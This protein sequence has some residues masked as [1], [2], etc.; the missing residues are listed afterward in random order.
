[1]EIPKRYTWDKWKR[2]LGKKKIVHSPKELFEVNNP[3]MNYLETENQE[4]M[5]LIEL[6]ITDEDNETN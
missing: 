2:T 6:L 1:M 4:L 3:Y 5:D